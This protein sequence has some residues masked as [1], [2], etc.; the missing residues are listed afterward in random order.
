MKILLD[1]HVFLWAI[2][3]DRR[4]SRSHRD[5]Y[6]NE[7]HDL[8]LSVAS[9][10]EMLI[11]SGIGKLPLPLPAAPGSPA[12]LDKN[13]IALLGIRIPH[14]TELESL[15]PLHKD[16]FDRMIVA[17]AR[18]EKMPVLSSDPKILKYDVAVL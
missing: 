6:T 5:I 9:I 13:R 12:Q 8:Y 15:Q 16:P 11:K 14:L 18:A 10:W 17:Q 4:L 1:T 7:G 3:N 2:T